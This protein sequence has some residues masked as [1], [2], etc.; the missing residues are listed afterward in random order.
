MT[1]R[2]ASSSCGQLLGISD[3]AN[4]LEDRANAAFHPVC[5]G[6]AA[7]LKL[8]SADIHE[9]Q[10]SDAAAFVWLSVGLSPRVR[11]TLAMRA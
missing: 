5:T 3:R 7:S 1:N 9:I 6:K 8:L 10:R 2:V 4:R 11:R